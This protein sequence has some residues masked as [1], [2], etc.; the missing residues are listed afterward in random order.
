MT[1]LQQFQFLSHSL[2]QRALLQ[3]EQ[4]Y[5]GTSVEKIATVV[6][7]KATSLYKHF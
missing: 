1:K 6:G 5:N 3:S 7:I 4:G 2:H